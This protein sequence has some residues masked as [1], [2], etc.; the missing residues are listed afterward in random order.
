MPQMKMTIRGVEALKPPKSGQVDYWDSG[1]PGFGIRV[2]AGG[3]KSWTLMYRHGNRKRRL[4]IGTYPAMTLARARDRASAA[5]RQVADGEDPAGLKRAEKR[6]ETFAE[7][8]DDYIERYAKKRKR[9]WRSD[10]RCLK[11]DVLPAF[12]SRKVKDVERAD[13]RRLLQNIAARGATIQANRTH[14]LVSKIFNWAISEDLATVNPAQGIARPG[15]ERQRDRILTDDEIRAVWKACEQ[16]PLAYGIAAKL[17]L[18]T[19]QRSGEVT[20]MRWQD[21]DGDMWTIPA[22]HANNGLAHRVPLN[23]Q[24]CDEIDAIGDRS[25]TSG[26]VFQSPRRDE[27]LVSTWRSIARIRE[28]SGVDFVMHDLRRTA[29]SRM[30]GDLGVNRL[31]VSKILNHVESGVTAVYDRHSYDAEKRHALDAWGRRLEEIVSGDSTGDETV[32]P[33]RSG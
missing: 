28:H 11:K 18:L 14:A 27:P 9:T 31:T 25:Q 20:R 2:N 15:I 26:W 8:A 24:A 22:E 6:A 16:E 23:P 17:R 4:T 32:V 7:L 33:L 5:L 30:T 21:I 12:G 29:A 10:E 1:L 13:I 19:A 3:R